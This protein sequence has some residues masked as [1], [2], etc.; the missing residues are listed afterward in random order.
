MTSF[1]KI[2]KLKMKTSIKTSSHKPSILFSLCLFFLTK[3]GETCSTEG[4]PVRCYWLAADQELAEHMNLYR[5]A[6]TNGE[7]QHVPQV[8]Y[9]KYKKDFEEPQL[10]EGFVAVRRVNFVPHF[11]SDDQRALFC[12]YY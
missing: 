1:R 2:K 3:N 8:A 7:V 9:N 6:L 10:S 5:E 12:Q 4:V 11:A